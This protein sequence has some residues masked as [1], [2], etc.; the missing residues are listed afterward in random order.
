MEEVEDESFANR[1]N[2]WTKVKLIQLTPLF[3]NN[4]D[5]CKANCRGRFDG[6]SGIGRGQQIWV[7]ED[8][9]DALF[10]RLVRVEREAVE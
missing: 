3:L 6:M 2:A 4:Y 7:F 10:F 5:W 8:P 9:E 1:W